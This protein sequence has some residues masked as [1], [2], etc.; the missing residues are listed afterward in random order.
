MPAPAGLPHLPVLFSATAL[1]LLSPLELIAAEASDEIKQAIHASFPRYD[2]SAHAKAQTEQAARS[3]RK[4]VPAPLPETKP[5]TPATPAP[6]STKEKILEL[7]KI[8]IRPDIDPPKRLPRIDPPARPINNVPAELF[9][10]AAGRDAR[11]VKNHLTK[12]QQ[13]SLGKWA[14][15]EAR[16]AEFRQQKA[17]QMDELAAMIE[18]QA[19]LG[20][21]PKEIKKLRAEYL[22]LYYSGP[23]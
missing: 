15:P 18:M 23:K 17:A 19:V 7:P 4:N 5:G 1:A 6:A 3:V 16:Q 11:L 9:E 8:T 2:S 21:D 22:K 14:V 20:L 12:L 13:K 10:S